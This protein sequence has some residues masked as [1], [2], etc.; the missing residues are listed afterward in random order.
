MTIMFAGDTLGLIRE[1]QAEKCYVFYDLADLEDTK[2]KGNRSFL[3]SHISMLQNRMGT[4]E[5][6]ESQGFEAIVGNEPVKAIIV[7]Q[8]THGQEQLKHPTAVIP[9][10]TTA[11]KQPMQATGFQLTCTSLRSSTVVCCKGSGR[12][13]KTVAAVI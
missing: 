9:T 3:S 10:S 1:E 8:G 2:G 11:M 12:A 13:T 5:E 4:E 6:V 7:K